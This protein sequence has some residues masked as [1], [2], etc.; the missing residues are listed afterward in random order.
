METH[1]EIPCSTASELLSA[2]TATS[3][4]FLGAEDMRLFRGESDISRP[5]VP[6]AF[7]P[8]GI[9]KLVELDQLEASGEFKECH[10]ATPEKGLWFYERLALAMFYRNA[11]EQSLPLPPLE[12]ETHVELLHRSSSLA[13]AFTLKRQ[14]PRKELFPI[15]ALAQHYGF[16]TRLL[17]WS[18]D[19]LASAYFAA[20]NGLNYMDR[21]DR[22]IGVWQT[23]APV[24]RSTIVPF[25]GAR[26]NEPRS[27]QYIAV[28]D[29]PYA[30]N[31]NLAAQKGRF[32]LA[33]ERNR[34]FEDTGRIR[35]S[36]DEIFYDIFLECESID[37]TSMLKLPFETS[38]MFLK[39]SL[40][41]SESADLLNR[42]HQ[43]G[44]KASRVFPG[45]SSCLMNV[46]E[47]MQVRK[48]INF[49]P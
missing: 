13:A 33:I 23:Y 5:L 17:D 32:T 29:A 4:H 24:L 21:T 36:L 42:L 49:A 31:P 44:Y 34:P 38:H 19:P 7:R 1:L 16:P 20:R 37:K 22:K 15:M 10:D 3:K 25:L 35:K 28:V 12:H 27:T 47:K 41:V 8:E 14:W 45:Y 6:T 39:Y 40:P 46:N 43:R 9:K 30:G 26:S 48:T 2:L 11:N 18:G